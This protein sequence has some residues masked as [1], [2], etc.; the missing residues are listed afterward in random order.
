MN[1]L[2]REQIEE[3]KLRISPDG[4]FD[5]LQQHQ[6]ADLE[7]MGVYMEYQRELVAADGLSLGYFFFI[8]QGSFEVSKVDA[9]TQ[10]KCVL[11]S[12]D[13]GQCFGEMSFFTAAPA[14]AN[15]MAADDVV[16]WAIPHESLRQFIES[17]DGG[18]RVAI[19]I[20]TLLARRV[21]EGNTRLMGMSSSLSAYFGSAAR[22]SE[23]KT[24]EAPRAVDHAEMEIPDEVFDS[25]ARET[26]GL[27]SGHHLGEEQRATVR[28]KIEANEIDIVPWLER[29]QRGQPLRVRL[30]FVHDA[31]A[32]RV[33]VSKAPPT[34]SVTPGQPTVVR[35][36]QVRARVAPAVAYVS[37]PPN[38]VWKW[39]NI[40]SFLILPA[41]TAYA[42]FLYL[43]METRETMSE[44]PGFKSLP[45]QGTLRWFIFRTNTQSSSVVL[46]QG[47]SY[48][49]P[50]S[51]PKTVR[52]KAR[53]DFPEKNFDARRVTVRLGTKDGGALRVQETVTLSQGSDATRLFSVLLPPNAY[54]LECVCDD[55]PPRA[56]LSAKLV[57]IAEY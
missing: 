21:Q 7:A 2:S 17:H 9:E 5:S 12:I 15:V 8:I 23:A 47:A 20:A 41:L 19:N 37:R 13:K 55:W 57:I 33:A 28:S 30:K 4:V 6:I 51:L 48:R 31:P 11:A 39:L 46:K 29:G 35:V 27:P 38:P 1:T 24:V 10:K 54:V 22:A 3:R 14:S 32:P 18:A 25:F 45:F 50:M 36:P 53:L 49:L 43:P 44:S 40:A 52:L 16:C 26:L 56:E 34:P 42:I